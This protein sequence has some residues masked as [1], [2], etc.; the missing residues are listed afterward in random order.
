MKIIIALAGVVLIGW[1]SSA[2]DMLA[3]Q[4]SIND[5]KV[6]GDWIPKPGIPKNPAI[7]PSFWATNKFHDFYVGR[8]NWDESGLMGFVE[9][10]PKLPRILLIGDSI[11]MGYTLDV[12][13]LFK[14]K[15]NVYRIPGNGGDMTRFLANYP[16]YLGA[17]TNWD[18]IHFNWGLHDL[19]RQDPAKKYD[20][21]FKPRY[22]ETE[23]SNHLEQCVA[24]LKSTGAHLVWASTTPIPPNAPGRVMGDE[25]IRNAIAAKIMQQHGIEIDD[26]Y[27]LLK[28]GE[29]YHG[30]PGNV[31]FTGTGYFEMAKQITKVIAPKLGISVNATTEGGRAARLV[32]HWRFDNNY[33]DELT[34]ASGTAADPSAFSFAAG[35]LSPCLYCKNTGRSKY[36][37]LGTKAGGLPEFS[38]TLWFKAESLTRPATLIGKTGDAKENVGWQILLRGVANPAGECTNGALWFVI[39]NAAQRKTFNLRY[40]RPAF[41]VGQ[42]KWHHLACTFKEDTGEAKI[43]VDGTMITR[44]SGITL[45]AKDLVS[46]LK[47]NGNAGG[48]KGW[49]DELQIWDGVLTSSQIKEL[50]NQEGG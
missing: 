39:G 20:S 38:V 8:S 34:Q 14:G 44:S 42:G 11:S 26:L 40:D 23:Y 17:G 21:A 4:S 16:R 46:E 9:Y 24:I 41:T 1:Y 49:V 19:V 30:G 33:R 3:P 32:N 36:L 5:P 45:S 7:S 22:T 18:L 15:A 12:R 13:Q 31:H 35:Q 2:A 28:N 6:S 47:I 27:T 10:N 48:F 25:V 43:F 29:D 50:V 37:S